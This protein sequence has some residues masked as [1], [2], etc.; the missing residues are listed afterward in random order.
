MRGTQRRFLADIPSS[1]QFFGTHDGYE[2]HHTRKPLSCNFDVLR[3]DV[4]TKEATTVQDSHFAR[5]PASRH[6][7]QHEITE[8]TPRLD[9][10]F[11]ESF[12]KNGGM[13]AC[14]LV[15]GGTRSHRVFPHV[16]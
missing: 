14:N 4:E 3:R 1:K 16:A 6:G 9:V 12:G 8:V 2:W 13:T 5:G 15:R 10:V 11:R 7:V